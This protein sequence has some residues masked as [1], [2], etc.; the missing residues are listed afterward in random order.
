MMEFRTT[1]P[2]KAMHP[3]K[4]VKPKGFPVNTRPITAPNSERGIADMTTSGSEIVR[5]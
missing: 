2:D 3:I 1:M 4:L 5:N